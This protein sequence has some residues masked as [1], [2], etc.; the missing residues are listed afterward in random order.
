MNSNSFTRPLGRG[1]FRFA[2]VFLLL[3]V[4]SVLSAC[5]SKNPATR[6]YSFFPSQAAQTHDNVTRSL[7]VGPI[8]LPEY[9]ENPAVVSLTGG[10][11][12]RISGYHAWAGSLQDAITR[13]AANDLAQSFPAAR[14]VAFPWDNRVRPEFQLR[15][16]F[17]EFAGE[18]G[19]EI[20]AGI[21]W[22]LLHKGEDGIIAEGDVRRKMP[23]PS[24]DVEAYVQTLNNLLNQMMEAIAAD[25]A[26]YLS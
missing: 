24:A 12:L 23:A 17:S 18:R 9:L 20:R 21:S 4:L 10:Q 25:A 11:Q 14:V 15:L 3:S 2:L 8:M 1:Y 19:G 6:F 5:A 16:R 7:G 13:V 26:Q 22:T